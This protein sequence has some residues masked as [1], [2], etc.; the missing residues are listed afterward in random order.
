MLGHQPREML[1]DP[2]QIGG[3]MDAVYTLSIL[4]ITPWPALT[5]GGFFVTL[6]C[7]VPAIRHRFVPLAVLAFAYILQC[8]IAL[9]FIILDPGR[10][11]S[12]WLD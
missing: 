12:W 9:G 7:P 2:K 8:T 3:P 11:F 10:I 4:L 5:A 1:N 6:L